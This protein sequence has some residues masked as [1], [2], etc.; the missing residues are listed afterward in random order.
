MSLF[1]IDPTQDNI[2]SGALVWDILEKV[3]GKMNNFNILIIG[4]SSNV[5]FLHQH[6][7]LLFD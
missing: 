6:T 3:P 2:G 1:N 4:P 5:Q 7:C